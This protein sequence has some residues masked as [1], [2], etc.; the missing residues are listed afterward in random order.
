MYELQR[1]I[2]P[3]PPPSQLSR[4]HA[5]NMEALASLREI[6]R[7]G[8]KGEE[9][10]FMNFGDLFVAGKREKIEEQLKVRGGGGF[11]FC[12]AFNRDAGIRKSCE[13][14][15]GTEEHVTRHTSHVTHHTSHVT[16]HTSHF[17]ERA[18]VVH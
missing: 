11:V 10:V 17:T 9:E 8:S 13:M 18:T 6:K 4:Q 3:P 2:P 1:D 5:R 16:R 7:S 14:L 15:H 12:V